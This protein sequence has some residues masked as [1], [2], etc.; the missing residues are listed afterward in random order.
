MQS[1]K[2]F[3]S[4]ELKRE[5]QN[6]KDECN[7]YS[8]LVEQYKILQNQYQAV[9]EN[10]EQQS[11]NCQQLQMQ[12]EQTNG[13]Y[14]QGSIGTTKHFMREKSLMKKTINELEMRINT[15]KQSLTTKDETIKK[16][17]HLIKSAS[18]KIKNNDMNTNN[19]EAAHY[20]NELESLTTQLE[21]SNASNLLI[22]E[23]HN[24]LRD[25]L[26]EEERKNEQLRQCI[27][28]LQIQQK[29]SVYETSDTCTQIK[30]LENQVKTLQEELSAS[31][32]AMQR[33]VHSSLNENYE[34][35]GFNSSHVSP[36]HV[37]QNSSLTNSLTSSSQLDLIKS[38]EKFLKEK[39]ET[40]K[41]DL[42][43]KETEIQQLKTKF[44]TCESKEKDL[45][46]YLSLL[47]ESI[48]T[49]DQ[50]ITM[51]QSEINDLRTRIRDKE[52]FIEKKNQHL[53]SIQLEKHQ[54]DSDIGELRDQMDIK[55]RKINVLN[56]KVFNL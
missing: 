39:I 20:L 27:Q 41:F 17:F 15:Q 52:S 40:F 43:K 9:L 33:S 28:Q 26:Q 3:W 36:Q 51:Q 2:Q 13:N 46:H 25:R 23:Q 44:E 55:E 35:T 50:Q 14:D 6:R 38:N 30:Q 49:K 34:S 53:Q 1:I 21:A 10:Y 56:R 45:Q 24:N 29:T 8:I 19:N 54:R 4:P 18:N 37:K 22:T 32:N 48:L 5:R 16:L 11:I 31:K 47:K 12:L 7:K 42:S